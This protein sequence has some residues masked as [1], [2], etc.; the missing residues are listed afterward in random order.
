MFSDRDLTQHRASPLGPEE[1][2]TSPSFERRGR[3]AIK[4]FKA[5][6][7][8]PEPY[9]MEFDGPGPYPLLPGTIAWSEIRGPEIS[10]YDAEQ[11]P[12]PPRSWIGLVFSRD[13][14]RPDR[15][16]TTNDELKGRRIPP[17]KLT[18]R[19]PRGG[20]FESALTS[21]EE[22]SDRSPA[23]GVGLFSPEMYNLQL[24]EA[25]QRSRF[26]VWTRQ[27]WEPIGV[28]AQV[29]DRRGAQTGLFLHTARGALCRIESDNPRAGEPFEVVE[30]PPQAVIENHAKLLKGAGPSDELV[31]RKYKTFEEGDLMIHSSRNKKVGRSWG[32][33]LIHD[34]GWRVSG[35]SKAQC[36]SLGREPG[37]P[38]LRNREL[39]YIGKISDLERLALE[40]SCSGYTVSTVASDPNMLRI[41]L[42]DQHPFYIPISGSCSAT[43]EEG[44]LVALRR[45]ESQVEDAAGKPLKLWRLDASARDKRWENFSGIAADPDGHLGIVQFYETCLFTDGSTRPVWRGLHLG[46]RGRR[47]FSNWI[48]DDP[49][50]VCHGKY[51]AAE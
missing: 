13:D 22:L 5:A 39:R 4:G 2:L 40:R 28:G 42:G 24:Q 49:R 17:A 18:V 7:L 32:L 21:V 14:F 33:C 15:I 47:F 6:T 37:S 16:T 20:L 12:H 30:L 1:Q 9:E 44:K 23:L 26:V 48:T 36:A 10:E 3:V 41:R 38:E 51:F 11:T 46:N 43:R 27:G 29:I 50:A 35:K 19:G 8:S 25:L 31:S 45:F 34:W